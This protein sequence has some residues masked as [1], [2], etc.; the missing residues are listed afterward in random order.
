MMSKRG[1]GLAPFTLK[2]SVLVAIHPL[3]FTVCVTLYLPIALYSTNG[4]FAVV[5]DGFGIGAGVT[6]V[7]PSLKFH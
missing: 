3:E 7:T 1:T 2:E 5:A 6:G 4:F